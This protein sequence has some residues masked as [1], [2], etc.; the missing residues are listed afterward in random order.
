LRVAWI[1]YGTLAQPTGGYVYDR[2]VVEGLEAGG[3]AVEVVGIE[4]GGAPVVPACDV[5]VGDALCAPELGP[6]FEQVACARVLLVH[7]LTSWELERSDRAE[8]R[9]LEARALGASDHV[10][11]TSAVT[12]ARLLA[13]TGRK[14]DVIPPGADRLPRLPRPRRGED[15]ELLFVG[16]LL[17]RK[18]VLSVLHALDAI[19]SPRLSL[20]MAGDPTRDPESA[21]EVARVVDASPYLSRRTTALGVVSDDELA[22]RMARADVLV[23]PSSL[24]GYG[25]VLTEALHAG[26]A[27]LA[28]RPAA[29]AAGLEMHPG[30]LSFEDDEGLREALRRIDRELVDALQ[31]ASHEV[32]LPTW[33]DAV[34]SFVASLTRVARAL[35]REAPA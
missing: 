5:A 13:E 6:A 25:M 17:P 4:P 20:V 35:R 11:A 23:L 31:R 14:A 10:I 15:L 12:A 32:G 16:S 19:R 1:V 9:A 27:V 26:L 24:E 30:V 3:H 34:A 18:R 22:Q 7:H 28:S 33:R 29:V 8:R 2:L 21:R